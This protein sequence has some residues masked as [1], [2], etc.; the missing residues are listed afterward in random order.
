MKLL[1]DFQIQHRSGKAML[2]LYQECMY[3]GNDV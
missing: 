1:H 2:V 3:E